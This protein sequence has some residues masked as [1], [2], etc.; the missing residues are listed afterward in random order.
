M[1]DSGGR[2]AKRL[3]LRLAVSE[4]LANLRASPAKTLTSCLVG[5]MAGAAVV[6]AP[7]LEVSRIAAY[8][9]EL[10]AA[11]AN[12]FV[13]QRDDRQGLDAGRCD[14]LRS[15]PGVIG[16]GGVASVRRAVSSVDSGVSFD[17]AKASPGY[18]ALVWPALRGQPDTGM[19]VVGA[20][21][22]SRLGIADSG[23]LPYV[24]ARV[25]ERVEVMAAPGQPRSSEQGNLVVVPVAP[26][27]QLQECWVEAAPGARENVEL[28]L[29][30]WFDE[31]ART[32][33]TPGVLGEPLDSSPAGQLAARLSGW[34]PLAAA[35][36]LALFQA[37]LWLGRRTDMGLYGLLGLRGGRLALM[38]A[39]D[40]AFTALA[41]FAAGALL[42]GAWLAPQLAGV[43]LAVTA[44]DFARAATLVTLVPLAVFGMLAAIKPFDAIRGR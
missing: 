18:A 6:T 40:W 27:G 7:A 41:P 36:V 17:L 32:L 22:A 42:A 1:A 21:V 23:T 33:V 34:V 44:W 43:V 10:V 4:A 25:N 38:V 29:L 14:S 26:A 19:A 15:L 5:L 24:V 28:L 37:A 2:P 39:S 20:R 30:G 31:A 16:A 11:G 8:N 3:P 13:V 9:D 12:L 35:A